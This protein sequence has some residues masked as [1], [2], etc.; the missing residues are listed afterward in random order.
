MRGFGKEEGAEEAAGWGTSKK[1][2]SRI[3]TRMFD[4]RAAAS[5]LLSEWRRETIAESVAD[6]NERK[7]REK[8]EFV[9][10]TEERV[11]TE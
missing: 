2:V 5:S 1:P 7:G 6:D 3:E 10:G 11:R 9:E 4:V 8:F